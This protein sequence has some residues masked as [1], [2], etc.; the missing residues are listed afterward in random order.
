MGDAKDREI[1]ILGKTE[2]TLSVRGLGITV[3]VHE[4]GKGVQNRTGSGTRSVVNLADEKRRKKYLDDGLEG[5]ICP[6]GVT[7]ASVRFIA[8]NPRICLGQIRIGFGVIER[9][10]GTTEI[11]RAIECSV[12]GEH[13]KT[14]GPRRGRT[15]GAVSTDNTVRFDDFSTVPLEI[16][17]PTLNIEGT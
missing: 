17:E 6:I 8:V 16:L 7:L 14:G 11:V 13:Q 1:V 9:V 15:T 3:H 10:Q 5:Q 2:E 4:M 12:E